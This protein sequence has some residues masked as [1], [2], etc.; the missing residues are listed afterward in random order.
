M[1]F[2]PKTK[3][4]LTRPILKMIEGQA[5]HILIE[6]PMYVGKE[7]KSKAG[8]KNKEPAT[9]ANVIDLETGEPAQ[10]IVSAVVKSVLNEEYPNNGYVHKAFSITKQA[11]QPGKQ[12]NPFS[13]AEIEVPTK[14]TK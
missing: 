2:T 5:R 13:V 14:V 7:M 11:K 10:I 4:L 6:A 1:S 8:E 3:R 12:Y 9:L